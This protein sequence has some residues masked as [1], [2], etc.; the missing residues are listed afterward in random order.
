MKTCITC[1]VEKS[2]TEFYKRAGSADGVDY[3]CKECARERRNQY[4]AKRDPEVS[5]QYTLNRI[6]G[7]IGI[8]TDVARQ[9]LVD[10][11]YK[12]KICGVPESETPKSLCVD[13][14]HVTNKFRGM[15]CNRCNV[16]LANFRDNPEL[17]A[18]AVK[19]LK[20]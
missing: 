20:S 12:C 5:R 18:E 3:H 4:N 11:D 16:G 13:H 1:K 6:C 10:Q 15:L 7:I 14:C 8:S 9:A 2:E 19:Y 17:L